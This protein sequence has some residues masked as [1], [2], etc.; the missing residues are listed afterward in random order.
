MKQLIHA[1]LTCLF[2]LTPFLQSSA[3]SQKPDTNMT[4]QTPV[5]I[6]IRLS[7]NFGE[8]RSGH[9]HAG[10]DIKTQGT[11]GKNIRAIADGYVSRINVSTGGYGKALYLHHPEHMIT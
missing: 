3:Y 10:I 8:L 6:P 7:G 9:F 4:F 1:I 11:S 5:D 2:F